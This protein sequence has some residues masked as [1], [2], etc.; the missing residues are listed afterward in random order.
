MRRFTPLI[1]DETYEVDAIVGYRVW[2]PQVLNGEVTLKALSA[3]ALWLPGQDM[4]AD[5]AWRAFHKHTPPGQMC[6]C[7]LWAYDTLTIL[8]RNIINPWPLVIGEVAGY[9]DVITHDHG[10]RSELA[11]ITGICSRGEGRPAQLAVLAAQ[12]YDVPLL[13]PILVGD[14]AKT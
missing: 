3:G 9:G 8:L 6:H 14:R 13:A 7:G 1:V 11:R 12:R 5:C 4:R 2:R 10:W